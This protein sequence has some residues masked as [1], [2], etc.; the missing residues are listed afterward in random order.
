MKLNHRGKK[1]MFKNSDNWGSLLSCLLM[2]AGMFSLPRMGFSTIEG[3]FVTFWAFLGF[4][5]AIGFLKNFFRQ[6]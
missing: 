6:R 2:S 5:V 4:L 3:L 1:I